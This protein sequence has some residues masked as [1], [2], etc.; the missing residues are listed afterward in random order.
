MCNQPTETISPGSRARAAGRQAG[1]TLIEL[2]V[3]CAVLAI[4]AAIAIPSYQSYILRG[5]IPNATNGL[6]AA[7]AQMEQYFQDYRSYVQAGTAPNPPCVTPQSVGGNGANADF[8]I[9]CVPVAGD[10]LTLPVAT[11]TA[12][13]Y[14]IW[15]RGQGQMAGFYYTIDN[16]TIQESAE[17]PVWGTL[18]CTNSWVMKPGTC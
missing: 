7:A 5:H 3:A 1:F 17:G 13:T 6:S 12:T 4:L 10:P 16:N 18:V 9:S 14:V 8:V 15:A 2:M 11:N